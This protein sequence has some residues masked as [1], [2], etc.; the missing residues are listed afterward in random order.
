VPDGE[1][2]PAAP[3]EPSEPTRP[4]GPSDVDRYLRPRPPKDVDEAAVRAAND[5]FY[6]AFEGRDLDAMSDLWAHD[7]EVTCVHPGWTTLRGW[8]EVAASWA[9]LFNGPQR[10]QFIVTEAQVVVAGD[11]AWVTCAENLL[12][13]DGGATVAVLNL[14]GRDPQGRWRML[15]HHGSPVLGRQVDEDGEGDDRF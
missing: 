3:S 10:L 2:D 4:S 7:P 14:F 13:G 8:G 6:A 12:A 15:A 1:P 5:A 11:I 9:A